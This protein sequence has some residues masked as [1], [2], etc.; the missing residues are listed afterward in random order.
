MFTIHDGNSLEKSKYVEVYKAK[1][2]RC[3]PLAAGQMLA[4]LR[5]TRMALIT[6]D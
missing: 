5:G 2:K 6:K 3:M 4:G 1:I